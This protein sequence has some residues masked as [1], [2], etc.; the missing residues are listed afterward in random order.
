MLSVSNSSAAPGPKSLGMAGT[1]SL[2]SAYLGMP[3]AQQQLPTACELGGGACSEG[4]G[5]TISCLD[6]RVDAHKVGVY[7]A[8]YC[9]FWLPAGLK[10]IF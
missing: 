10:R 6:Y 9:R 8:I 5:V 3:T 4:V 1:E 7:P 2:M